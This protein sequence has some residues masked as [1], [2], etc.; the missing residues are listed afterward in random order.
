MFVVANYDSDKI[1][2]KEMIELEKYIYKPIEAETL[3][4]KKVVI[5]PSDV[6]EY[7]NTENLFKDVRDYIYRY[8]DAKKTADYDFSTYYVHHSYLYDKFDEV[9]YLQNLGGVGRGKTRYLLTIGGL[10]YRAT[11]ISGALTEAV[12][13]HLIDIFKGTQNIDEG[14]WSSSDIWASV[15]KILNQGYCR[16]MSIIRMR[17]GKDGKLFPVAYEPFSPKT[18]STRKPFKDEALDSRCIKL[19]A[20]DPEDL[21]SDI[22]L[23]LTEEFYNERQSLINK[24]L[25]WRMRKYPKVKLDKALQ[26][27][28][29]CSE[30]RL[31][32]IIIPV[33]SS[34]NDP[35]ARKRLIDYI[36]QREKDLIEDRKDTIEYAIFKAL[37]DFATH[38]NYPTVGDVTDRVNLPD[39]N[40]KFDLTSQRCGRILKNSF[41]IITQQDEAGYKR[42]HWEKEQLVRIGK[43]FGVEIS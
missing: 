10:C 29:K 15:F 23:N 3:R 20:K 32:Q 4:K 8:W 16:G 31:K 41:G 14:D 11:F 18:L 24:L 7:G 34:V 21:R 13:F 35:I 19:Y 12:L 17:E 36:S 38:G 33:I 42:I 43:R 26:N 30:P 9:P 28:I 2:Y 1:D 39:N 27:E 22:P 40:P 25:L 37:L 6:I 5:F